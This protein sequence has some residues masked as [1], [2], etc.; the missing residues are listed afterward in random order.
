MSKLEL[1]NQMAFDLTF[2]VKYLRIFIIFLML[3]IVFVSASI[4]Y[5]E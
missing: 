3:F 2:I 5:D 4:I 1:Q